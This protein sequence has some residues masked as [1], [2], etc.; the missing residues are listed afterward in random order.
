MTDEFYWT[1]LRSYNHIPHD[2]RYGIERE[3]TIKV[4]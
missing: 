4:N 1:I 3:K 2:G